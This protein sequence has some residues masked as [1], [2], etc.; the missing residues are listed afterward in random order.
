MH[1][2]FQP[3]KTFASAEL[4]DKTV[5]LKAAN[6]MSDVWKCVWSSSCVAS[7]IATPHSSI[8]LLGKMFRDTVRLSGARTQWICE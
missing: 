1:E 7:T 3:V 4:F 8:S 2:L 5:A 6:G